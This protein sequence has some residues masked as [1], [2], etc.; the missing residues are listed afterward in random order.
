[1]REAR[2]TD[3]DP[4]LT[5]LKEIL[6]SLAVPTT[7]P[8]ASTSATSSAERWLETQRASALVEV[9]ALADIT[10][11]P[12]VQLTMLR[13]GI[14]NGSH[15]CWDLDTGARVVGVKSVVGLKSQLQKD[16]EICALDRHVLRIRGR[17]DDESASAA[18]S[19]STQDAHRNAFVIVLANVKNELDV[20]GLEHLQCWDLLPSLAPSLPARKVTAKKERPHNYFSCLRGGDQDKASDAQHITLLEELDLHGLTVA[21][22]NVEVEELLARHE[23]GA[24][25][26]TH[27]RHVHLV[28]GAGKNSE[29]GIAQLRPAVQ[30]LLQK[31][32]ISHGT[33]PKNTGTVWVDVDS[34]Q[35]RRLA[36]ESI[37][38]VDDLGYIGD[39]LHLLLTVNRQLRRGVWPRLT[40]A[41]ATPQ[42]RTLLPATLFMGRC[43]FKD[44]QLPT[45]SMCNSHQLEAIR[46]ITHNVSAIQGPP[47][48]GKTSVIANILEHAIPQLTTLVT[49]VQN[50]AL[51]PLAQ[52]L[53][54]A[55]L[56]FV[57][58]AS[59]EGVEGLGARASRH[60]C[61]LG[62]VSRHYTLSALTTMPRAYAEAARRLASVVVPGRAEEGGGSRLEVLV[63]RYCVSIVMH[64]VG[65]L[66]RAEAEDDI[67]S[68]TTVFLSTIDR[69]HT[70]HH[71][72]C[73]R[74][75]ALKVIIVDEAGAVPEWKM[76]IL[77]GCGGTGAPELIVLVGDQ[78]QLP[79]FSRAKKT[80]VSV[81][82]RMESALPKGSVKMLGIQYRMPSQISDFLSRRFYD[83]LL[84]TAQVKRR[85][86]AQTPAIVWHD[87]KYRE[88]LEGSSY[89][90]EEELDIIA[91]LLTSSRSELNAERLAANAE[92]VMVIAFYS[93]QVRQ[94]QAR[95]GTR[96][97]HVSVMTVDAAQG[98]EADYVIL[99]CVRCN[100]SRSIGH[101]ADE[102]RVNVAF[103]RA[104]KSLIIVGSAQTLVRP[105]G[106]GKKG[107]EREENKEADLWH[108]FKHHAS[109]LLP[110]P[111]ITKG[112]SSFCITANSK[113]DN[114]SDERHAGYKVKLCNN[115][116]NGSCQF[117]ER[118]VF[119]HG[120]AQL[121]CRHWTEHRVCPKPCP[122]RHYTEDPAAACKALRAMP[123]S[124]RE[125]GGEMSGGWHGAHSG[126]VTVTLAS[127]L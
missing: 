25:S 86:D 16:V 105:W 102:R 76:P 89:Y 32:G 8:R 120:E 110:T 106:G 55:G 43:A 28:V 67:L 74:Q 19:A 3:G 12:Q 125:R 70:V 47:G 109:S 26:K 42:A 15:T 57:V 101:V 64:R 1:M 65:V 39:I 68:C 90:N 82:E 78:K 77:T 40:E 66:C 30:C 117:G 24:T 79:P 7:V 31:R 96:C 13:S 80:E 33:L 11:A 2:H 84:T 104:R 107:G 9:E 111:P 27:K 61:K 97:P 41:L 114:R 119:A 81:L 14:V 87:H 53:A 18:S 113:S 116:P 22:A 49:C 88:S 71:L 56:N 36:A 72:L 51:D 99:S 98:S 45:D 75:R 6:T 73:A 115:Y 124:G 94:V 38:T 5:V 85:Q 20:F 103:S 118:C 127:F 112:I 92:T 60:A 122:Y 50:K 121:R 126:A 69:A 123:G 59:E 37:V 17:Q 95:L 54:A 46:S 48:T 23:H 62:A 52:K 10:D 44:V 91:D 83:G 29:D 21:E 34:I 108:S 93:E 63:R 58:I 35:P 100:N 4:L